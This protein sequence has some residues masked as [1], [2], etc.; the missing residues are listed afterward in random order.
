LA[1]IAIIEQK[2]K[3]ARIFQFCDDDFFFFLLFFFF[4]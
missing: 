1:K 2:K 3:T 4:I